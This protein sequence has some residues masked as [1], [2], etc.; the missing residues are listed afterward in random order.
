MLY[1]LIENSFISQTGLIEK[2]I[3]MKMI[4]GSLLLFA[5]FARAEMLVCQL[6]GK[7]NGIT[8]IHALSEGTSESEEIYTDVTVVD[9][10]GQSQ[11]KS[12]VTQGLLNRDEVNFEVVAAQDS[13]PFGI[14]KSFISFYGKNFVLETKTYCNFYYQEEECMDGELLETTSQPVKCSLDW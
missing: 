1:D 11:V 13:S 9:S 5:S 12:D 3:Y 4:L 2:E 7:L 8:R 14:K 10:K 6:D